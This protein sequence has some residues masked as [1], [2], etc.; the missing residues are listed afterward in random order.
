MLLQDMK[1]FYAMMSDM[2]ISGSIAMLSSED[3]ACSMRKIC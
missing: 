2:G 1:R 3:I